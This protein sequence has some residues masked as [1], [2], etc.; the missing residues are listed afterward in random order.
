MRDV[1]TACAAAIR[2]RLVRLFEPGTG[3]SNA[4]APEGSMAMFTRRLYRSANLSATHALE[5]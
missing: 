4:T 5:R 1:P 3:T 2:A